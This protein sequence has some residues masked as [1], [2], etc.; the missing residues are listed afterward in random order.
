MGRSAIARDPT[1]ENPARIFS[2]K[3]TETRD[4]FENLIVYDYLRDSGERRGDRWDQPLLQW[5]KYADYG[6]PANR[7]FSYK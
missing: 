6:D 7:P 5:I 3:L 1:S 2:R 4:P